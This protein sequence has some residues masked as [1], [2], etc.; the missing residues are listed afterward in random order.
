MNVSDLI[1][2]LG[3]SVPEQYISLSTQGKIPEGYDP[4]TLCVL[5]LE[6]K[7]R[8]RDGWTDDKFYL[9]G[10]GCGN[11]Y[12]VSKS[13]NPDKVYLSSHDPQELEQYDVSLSEFIHQVQQND[14]IMTSV[15][16]GEFHIARSD[17]V[18][19]SILNPILL[20]E[21]IEVCDAFNEIT[22]L[23]YRE[24]KNP[25]TNEYTRF[26]M[27]GFAQ[28]N[29]NGEKYPIQLFSGRVIGRFE[30]EKFPRVNSLSKNLRAKIFVSS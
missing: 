10:D 13:L 19:E 22:Y 20:E 8:D 26:D 6:L 5:N 11:Y 7:S 15:K 17:I 27:P 23:G 21:W 14:P 9:S 28:F 16:K 4:K 30:I 1:G 18:G 3:A 24:G 29:C 12:F 2:Y 25:F